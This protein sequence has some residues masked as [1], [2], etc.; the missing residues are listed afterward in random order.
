MTPT[1]HN[2]IQPTARLIDTVLRAVYCIIK[3]GVAFE[4]PWVNYLVGELATNDKCIADNIPLTL[5]TKEE[6]ELAKVVH[7]TSHL[8]NDGKPLISQT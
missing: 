5:R 6:E 4:R 3:V 8:N 2:I 7:K 1:Q